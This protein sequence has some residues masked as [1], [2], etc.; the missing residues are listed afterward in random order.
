MVAAF[1]DSLSRRVRTVQP[2]GT[3]ETVQALPRGGWFKRLYV[4]A[5]EYDM[6]LLRAAL[7]NAPDSCFPHGRSYQRVATLLCSEECDARLY[8][9][10]H[11]VVAS[12]FA[13]MAVRERS[14]DGR[15]RTEPPTPP[16]VATFAANHL[17][18]PRNHVARLGALAMT[19]VMAQ[20][21]AVLEA[22]R[23]ERGAPWAMVLAS[24]GGTFG[25]AYLWHVDGRLQS[26]QPVSASLRS[27]IGASLVGVFSS[28]Q[29]VA[30][31]HAPFDDLR[32]VPYEVT[33]NSPS[34]C[35]SF[36]PL[37]LRLSNI[38][39]ARGL[40]TTTG[41]PDEPGESEVCI[42][43]TCFPVCEY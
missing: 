39:A 34:S 5:T 15:A 8:N 23:V 10:V 7:T 21:L 27:E 32:A 35:R 13:R 41:I 9:A 29:L 31:G 33:L 38:P 43:G 42:R 16:L 3:V 2:D 4:S 28:L 40:T 6:R 24:D 11:A 25:G 20:K 37:A 19:H 26:W 14:R 36:V 17:T 18:I 30:F 22:E 1:F 12:M